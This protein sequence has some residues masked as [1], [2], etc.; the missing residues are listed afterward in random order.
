ME[1]TSR[2]VRNAFAGRRKKS[3]MHRAKTAC[4]GRKRTAM[5]C[6]ATA[7]RCH[8]SSWVARSARSS[9]QREALLRETKD[10]TRVTLQ[11]LSWTV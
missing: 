7:Y 2:Q 5:R 8:G 9:D 3:Q 10:V 11:A 1:R 4:V 6:S